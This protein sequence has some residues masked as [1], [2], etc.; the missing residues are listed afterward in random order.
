MSKGHNGVTGREYDY[1]V[2]IDP[3]SD[4]MYEIQ[5]IKLNFPST[6]ATIKEAIN[7]KRLTQ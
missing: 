7:E 2:Y 5:L 1:C 3:K 6:K 4:E